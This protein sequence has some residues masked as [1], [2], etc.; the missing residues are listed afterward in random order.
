[1]RARQAVSHWAPTRGPVTCL[2]D[3][4]RQD[5]QRE[6][7]GCLPSAWGLPWA[8]WW[9]GSGL[10]V[11]RQPLSVPLLR[12]RTGRDC[13][14]SGMAEDVWLECCFPHSPD[15]QWIVC[16]GLSLGQDSLHFAGAR[17]FLWGSGAWGV[18]E[19]GRGSVHPP[20]RTPYGW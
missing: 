10:S 12:D 9:G 4:L 1:M 6:A 2:R 19:A 8:R 5:H 20:F 11:G 17:R 7:Q 13:P 3:P 14:L 15:G 16:R 18:P